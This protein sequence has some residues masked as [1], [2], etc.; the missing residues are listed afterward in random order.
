M[1]KSCIFEVNEEYFAETA[2]CINQTGADEPRKRPCLGMAKETFREDLAGCGDQREA[3]RDACELLGEHKYGPEGLLDGDNFVDDPDNA[4]PYFNLTPGHTFIARAGEDFEEIVVVTV[5]DEVL[6]ILE[7]N[8]RVVVDVVL[9][10]DD[11]GAYEAVEVTDDHYALATNGDVHYCGEISR[12][13]EDGVLVDLDG[14]FQAGRD[15]AKS[16]ILIKADPETGEAHRQEYFLGEAEDLV[17][18]I[19]G[20]GDET[21]VGPGEGG[22]GPVFP[23]TAMSNDRCVKT[24]EFIPPEPESGEYKYWIAGTGFVLG[25]A[26]EDGE[27]TGERDEV[28][29]IGEDLDDTLASCAFSPDDDGNLMPLSA[30]DLAELRDQLCRLSPIA[31]CEE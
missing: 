31:F 10:K 27:I 11:E 13:F 18:Y 15:L 19:A 4:N 14:S 24:E 12:N 9:V 30:E 20:A 2:K 22:D 1:H 28:L 23:C 17:Q 21:G 26:L 6:E 8:C 16:G 29:C 3:R 25:V 5:T 7:A